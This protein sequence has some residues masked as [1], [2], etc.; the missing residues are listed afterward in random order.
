M[1]TGFEGETATC[2]QQ[3]RFESVLPERKIRFL[4]RV[5]DAAESPICEKRV[6]N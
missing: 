6:A 5:G 4:Q 2:I 3:Q 1:L